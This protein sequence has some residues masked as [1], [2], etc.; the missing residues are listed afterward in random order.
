MKDLGLG[1]ALND[2][3]IERFWAIIHALG[4]MNG[5]GSAANGAGGRPKDGAE[6]H[7]PA[8]SVARP[9]AKIPG[10]ALTNTR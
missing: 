4:G 1:E 5:I 6:P 8:V 7:R 2:A 9:D 3:L 10:L